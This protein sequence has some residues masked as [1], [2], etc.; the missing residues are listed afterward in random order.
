M[1]RYATK[2]LKTKEHGPIHIE[3]LNYLLK[4]EIDTHDNVK[5]SHRHPSILTCTK[6]LKNRSALHECN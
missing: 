3:W 4:D 6:K 5:Q 1:S 2:K